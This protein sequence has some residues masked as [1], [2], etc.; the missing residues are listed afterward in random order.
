MEK[1]KEKSFQN[2]FPSLDQLYTML[3]KTSKMNIISLFIFNIIFGVHKLNKNK[4][5]NH[6]FNIIKSI[7]I[8]FSFVS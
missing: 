3:N 8:G 4:L 7:I 6:K 1:R 5:K 2:Y